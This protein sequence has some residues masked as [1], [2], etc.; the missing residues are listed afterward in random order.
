MLV[1]SN[2]GKHQL[3]TNM[4]SKCDIW[5][6]TAM[7]EAEIE[8]MVSEDCLNGICVKPVSKNQL[9]AILTRNQLL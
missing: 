7:N 1:G 9:E 3:H 5:A 2:E 6:I 8:D 4:K